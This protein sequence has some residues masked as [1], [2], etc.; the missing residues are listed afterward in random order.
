[1]NLMRQGVFKALPFFYGVVLRYLFIELTSVFI[2]VYIENV[3]NNLQKVYRYGC[4]L[5][6]I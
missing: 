3:M 4:V 2:M 1:V 6:L 5:S